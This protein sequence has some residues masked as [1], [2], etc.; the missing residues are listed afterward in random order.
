MR[1][2]DYSNR[3]NENALT[4]P[5]GAVLFILTGVITYLCW[6]MVSPFVS[7]LTWALALGV[8]LNP[9]RSRLFRRFSKTATAVFMLAGVIASIAV[10]VYFVSNSLISEIPSAQNFVRALV[11]PEVWQRLQNSPSWLGGVF[12]WARSEF[13][14]LAILQDFLSTAARAVAPAFGNS[15]LGV[16]RAIL[17]LFFFFFFVRDEESLITA[18][19]R[20]LP[21]KEEEMDHLFD[22][23]ALTVQATVIGRIAIGAIQGAIGG[24][25][26]FALGIPAP[27]FWGLLMAIFSMLPVIGAFVIWVPAALT[28]LFSGHF[29]RA[30][31]LVVGGVGLIHPVDNII[32]PL[33]VGPRAGLHPAVLLIA[34]V[35]GLVAFGPPGLVLGPL[36]ATMAAV[37][38]EIWHQRNNVPL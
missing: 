4:A 30:L 27:V 35:G 29:V 10:L 33:L 13:D 32:Y 37:L 9:I 7:A 31:I 26:F 20:S 36:I 6:L 15:A 11:Q 8:V 14:L 21:L 22:R 38:A 24:L 25:L 12:R 18:I 1:A 23:I 5:A 28:L 19:R 3:Q 16:S 17:S 2:Y 34:F